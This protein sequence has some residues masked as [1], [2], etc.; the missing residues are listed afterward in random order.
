MHYLKQQVTYAVEQSIL[1]STF[2]PEISFTLTFKECPFE[3]DVDYFD[4][5][6]LNGQFHYIEQKTKGMMSRLNQLCFGRNWYD[7][8]K[9]DPKEVVQVFMVTEISKNRRFHVHGAIQLPVILNPDKAWLMEPESFI[10][11]I[12][13]CWAQLK[14]TSKYQNDF[15][16]VTC[17][18]GWIKY[19]S[20]DLYKF[21]LQGFVSFSN[22]S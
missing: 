13:G 22:Y 10:R 18:S 1:N 12:N 2:R 5:S 6:K 14:S 9:R 11:A 15:R 4:Q 3:G 20:K 17:L 7:K 21:Q 16:P 19:I 8:Y